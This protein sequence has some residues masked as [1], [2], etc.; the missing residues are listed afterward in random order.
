[1]IDNNA[2]GAVAETPRFPSAQPSHEADA[3]AIDIA[4]APPSAR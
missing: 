4:P 2:V 3:F 1:M